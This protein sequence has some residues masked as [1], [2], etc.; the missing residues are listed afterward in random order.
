M[1]WL[2]HLYKLDLNK[3][4]SDS[5]FKRIR[6]KKKW[7]FVDKRN[8]WEEFSQDLLCTQFYFYEEVAAHGSS[9]HVDF[10]YMWYKTQIYQWLHRSIFT[11]YML[12][13]SQAHAFGLEAL[14]RPYIFLFLCLIPEF[15]DLL[16]PGWQVT[17]SSKRGVRTKSWFPSWGRVSYTKWDPSWGLCM[18]SNTSI[19]KS[20][21]LE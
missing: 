1:H 16:W 17:A 7:Y 5:C 13:W 21:Y 6:N 12:S 2:C 3:I 9:S 11:H 19:H 4:K 8:V 18:A 20:S 10:W 14:K 15:Q